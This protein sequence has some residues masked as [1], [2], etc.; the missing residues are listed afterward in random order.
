MTGTERPSC[1]E[2]T[3]ETL[4]ALGALLHVAAAGGRVE[5][6]AELQLSVIGPPGGWGDVL[7]VRY[8]SRAAFLA[9]ASDPGYREAAVHRTAALADS[10]LLALGG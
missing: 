9:M 8:P 6:D 10:R 2:P 7:L 4:A 1:V 5:L 3:R